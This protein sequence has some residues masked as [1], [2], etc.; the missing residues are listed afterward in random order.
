[1]M[2]NSN[3]NTIYETLLSVPGMNDNVKIDLRIPRKTVLL[4]TEVLREGLNHLGNSDTYC[5]A[6]VLKEEGNEEIKTI[7]TD[8]LEKAGLTALSAKLLDYSRNVQ[9][10]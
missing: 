2:N 10:K 3:L 8:S 7:I 6:S 9:S 1:M 5:L 4:F